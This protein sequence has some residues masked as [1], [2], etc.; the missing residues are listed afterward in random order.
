MELTRCVNDVPGA[1]V[2]SPDA[3]D[4]KEPRCTFGL[5][6]LPEAVRR[7]AI[8]HS[9]HTRIDTH[10]GVPVET[11]DIN[12]N[13]IL[14]DFD[15]WGRLNL[16]ARSW[17]KAPQ[18]NKT[19]QKRLDLAVRKADRAIYKPATEVKDWRILAIADYVGSNDQSRNGLLRSNLRRFESSDSYSGLLSKDNTT[20][21][22]A[23]F[24]D[25]LGRPVQTIREAD[26]CLGSTLSFMD[27]KL[28]V[29]AATE[30]DGRCTQ[31]ATSIVAPSASVD[32]LGRELQSFESYPIN[33]NDPAARVR[34][35]SN[36]SFL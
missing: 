30:L 15:R 5:G 32:A 22:S 25:G 34:P 4:I 18:E 24:S 26:V 23:I 1:G 7:K 27:S 16:I 12:A 14:Y 33:P 36:D 29:P 10:F 9:S 28:N 35:D 21:E 6:G 13:S 8:T 20:R 17:G 3:K 2:D 31:V 19:F 11:R